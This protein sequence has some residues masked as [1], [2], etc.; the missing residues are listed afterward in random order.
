VYEPAILFSYQAINSIILSQE[1][2]LHG[3]TC[4]KSSLAARSPA[5]AN[6]RQ[7]L[8]NIVF[9][10]S[11]D[12]SKPDVVCYGNPAIRTPNLDRIA[13]NGMRF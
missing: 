13:A 3:R 11:D 6:L 5:A 8:P 4:Y 10:I 12:H 7:D 1:C 9:L 2:P